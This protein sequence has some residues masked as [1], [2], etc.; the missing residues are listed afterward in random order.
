MP[1]CKAVAAILS[2]QADVDAAIAGL[3]SRPLKS[4]V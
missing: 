4:E 3:L 2:G 1:I